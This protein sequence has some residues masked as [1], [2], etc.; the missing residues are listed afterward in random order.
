MMLATLPKTPSCV[1]AYKL[2]NYDGLPYDVTLPTEAASSMKVDYTIDTGATTTVLSSYDA[3]LL[4]A[5]LGGKNLIQGVGSD[6]WAYWTTIFIRVRS[7]KYT[8]KAEVIPG[9]NTSLLGLSFL[10]KAGAVL[11]MGENT[12]QL[13]C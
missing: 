10:T 1:V 6:A 4:G 13:N 7:R 8:V 5:K 2:G 12:L 3:H 11:D 9:W